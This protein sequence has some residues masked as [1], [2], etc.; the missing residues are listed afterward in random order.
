[1]QH[2]LMLLDVSLIRKVLGNSSKVAP[3]KEKT[4]LLWENLNE[5]L[6]FHVSTIAGL[7]KREI[8]GE[9]KSLGFRMLKYSD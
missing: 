3:A 5:D 8:F 1:M 6:W 9:I 4:L 7:V 2:Q